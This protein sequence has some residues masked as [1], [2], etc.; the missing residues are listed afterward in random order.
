[1]ARADWTRDELIVTLDFY[2]KHPDVMP[3]KTSLEILEL[4]DFQYCGS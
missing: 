4:S 3:G 1:M 2:L